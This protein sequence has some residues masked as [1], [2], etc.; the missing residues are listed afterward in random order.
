MSTRSGRTRRPTERRRAPNTGVTLHR[1][2]GRSAVPVHSP[3]ADPQM[4]GSS[5]APSLASLT[6]RRCASPP[7]AVTPTP[8]SSGRDCARCSRTAAAAVAG[9]RSWTTNRDTASPGRWATPVRRL[10]LPGSKTSRTTS[11]GTAPGG[12]HRASGGTGHPGAPLVGTPVRGAPGRCGSRVWWPLCSWPAG[13]GWIVPSSSRPRPRQRCRAT[14]SSAPGRRRRR[15]RSGKPP[16]HRR[17]SWCRSSAW[18]SDRDWSR[19]PPAPASRTRSP[20]PG[21]CCRT[22]IRARSTSLPSSATAPRS[23]WAF[24]G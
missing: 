1:R 17:P 20:R 12:C 16:R 4:S 19:C 18:S 6:S 21:A 15:H 8:T 10:L 2:L 23:P 14:V 9:C 5:P 7:V 24:Q 22:P 11:M 13:P 3:T